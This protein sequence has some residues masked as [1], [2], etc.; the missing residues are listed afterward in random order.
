MTAPSAGS[1]RNRGWI[2]S[3][4][5]PKGRAHQCPE[6]GWRGSSRTDPRPTAKSLWPCAAG[7]AFY[8]F[9]QTDEPILSSLPRDCACAR[10]DRFEEAIG[11]A[12]CRAR[13]GQHVE[14]SGVA[15]SLKKKE[16]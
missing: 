13:V 5:R 8:R 1:S 4:I 2:F 10:S 6:P 12:S 11:R 16:K 3:A 7:P 15:E 9:D 14:L